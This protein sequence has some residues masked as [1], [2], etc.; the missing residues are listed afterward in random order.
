[1]SM[2]A[3]LEKTHCDDARSLVQDDNGFLVV[4]E[5]KL[6]IFQQTTKIIP[7]WEPKDKI[8]AY[9]NLTKLYLD[10][11]TSGGVRGDFW[12]HDI[13]M[14][15]L[16][17]EK[18]INY[19][20]REDSEKL[21]LQ[22]FLRAL[23][24]VK[25]SLL[26]GF[27]HIDFDLPFIIYKLDYYGIKHPFFISDK[28]SMFRTAQKFGKATKFN[29]IYCKYDDD[30]KSHIIDLYQQVLAKDFVVRNLTSHGL[31]NAVLEW[32]LRPEARLDLGYE[33]LLDCY[34]RKDWNTVE[35][36]L[37]YDLEDTELLADYLLPSVYYQLLF[38]DEYPLQGLATMGNA[39]KWSSTLRNLYKG[40]LVRDE[41][42][43]HIVLPG[44]QTIYP[45]AKKRF[46]GGKTSAYAGFYQFVSKYDVRSLYPTIQ[47]NYGICSIKDPL[48]WS[49]AV[50]KWAKTV[51][52]GF[53]TLK[54]FVK[55][56]YT[57]DVI[58]YLTAYDYAVECCFSFCEFIGYESN[59]INALRTTFKAVLDQSITP[60][61]FLE[62]I[63]AFGKG[64][65]NNEGSIKVYINSG[66]GF[67]G[68]V[69]I[70][71][72]DFVAASL[73]TAYGR[74]ILKFMREFCEAQGAQVVATD[75]DAV[76][77]C[78]ESLERNKEVFQALQK[79]LPPWIEIEKELDATA[80]FIP[81]VDALEEYN[82]SYKVSSKLAAKFWHK[83]FLN[84]DEDKGIMPENE[85]D[86]IASYEWICATYEG[87]KLHF[88]HFI[89]AAERF[90]MQFPRTE[91]LKKNYLIF[92]GDKVKAFGRYRKRDQTIMA[93]TWQIEYLQRYGKDPDL[94]KDFYE[95]TK[96][97]IMSGRY[98]VEDL[99][100]TKTIPKG[101]K[102]LLSVGNIGDKVTYYHGDDD[103]VTEGNYS[104]T[105]YVSVL[106]A[107]YSEVQT[108]IMLT[109]QKRYA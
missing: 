32:E 21:M 109:N 36:Y 3:T 96:A 41:D 29:A 71:F 40:V 7:F 86:V 52:L 79:A 84:E 65:F 88:D 85:A 102:A 56:S 44:G 46:K 8:K 73:V 106:D 74:Q 12:D 48:Y 25:P 5:N 33:G 34:R 60:G 91:G 43:N 4:D 24:K 100:I 6:D 101:S 22:K 53:K 89:A 81:P 38:C 30:S 76:I 28:P 19:I 10:I 62:T 83:V 45:S 55:S 98:P 47:E 1:M 59:R 27:N 23:I 72:N 67:L 95:S 11:E 35:R 70:P 99:T 77:V 68:A 93:K 105:H 104:V 57:G 78:T 66:Y 94:A 107:L 42:I 92:Q 61:N 9:S 108:S 103:Y 39:T 13:K 2:S 69:G 58:E 31:K 18:G 51:R 20:I 17:N 15:G 80:L 16:R 37:I 26:L 75:T 87:Q 50:K 90:D 97:I 54:N 14:I 63:E 64:F 82:K 49:L